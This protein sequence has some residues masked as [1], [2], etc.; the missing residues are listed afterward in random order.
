VI[1]VGNPRNIGYAVKLLV[2]VALIWWV[3]N[4]NLFNFSS[5]RDGL[6]NV[7]LATVFFVL[8]FMQLLLSAARNHLLVTLSEIDAMS[9]RA[10][11]SISWASS[12]LGCLLP[13]AIFGELFKVREL[14]NFNVNYP[15]DNSLYASFLSKLFSLYSL[16]L[17]S[18][19]TIFFVENMPKQVGAYAMLLHGIAFISVLSFWGGGKYFQSIKSKIPQNDGLQRSR[20]IDER[21]GCVIEYLSSI[22]KKK[23]VFFYSFAISVLIQLLNI[24]S[25]VL[26]IYT[27][28]PQVDIPAVDLFCVVPVG[29]L[30]MVLPVSLSG[31]GVGHVAFAK[32]LEIFGIS[33]GADVFTIFFAYSYVFNAVG[34]LFFLKFLKWG[35]R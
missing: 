28:N 25:F 26:I 7:R 34:V 19:F 22:Q 16:F 1:R 27:I 3:F 4:H 20:F 8:T 15:K 23:L 17:V 29:I 6:L 32:I 2:S 33:N 24:I 31:L 10:N 21:V 9:L 30:A 13:T 18:Y 5:I 12:F 14:M 35:K 11:L